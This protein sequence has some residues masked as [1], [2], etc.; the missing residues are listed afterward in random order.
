[1]ASWSQ[2]AEGMCIPKCDEVFET[3]RVKQ[4]VLMENS[5]FSRRVIDAMSALE[6][7]EQ[8]CIPHHGTCM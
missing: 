3:G 1:M 7:L 6:P 5:L 4:L 8:R 2:G